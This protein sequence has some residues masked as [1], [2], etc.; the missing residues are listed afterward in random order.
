MLRKL[1]MPVSSLSALFLAAQGVVASA[2]TGRLNPGEGTFAD[3]AALSD[4]AGLVAR[5]EIKELAQVEPARASGVRVGYGRFYIEGKTGALLIGKA[6]LGE[7][8][9][10]LVD[11]PLDTYGDGPNLKRQDVF[12][13]ARRVPARPDELQLVTPTAQL[14]WSPK[15][16]ARLR[17]LLR[18]MVS[19]AAPPKVTGVREF[20]HVPGNLAGQGRT[21][22]FL[23]TED[24]SA[25]SIAVA[26][27][28][29]ASLSWGVSFSEVAAKGSNAPKR[30]TLE[31]YR[32]ACL[33]PD[34]PPPGA[35]LSKTEQ[36]RARALADYSF[37]LNELR[38]CNRTL[39]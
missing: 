12:V 32:L 17:E 19:Q 36:S 16:A 25:A 35:N 13:F 10:Y 9:K 38:P 2:Q 15:G 30:N 27:E 22:I 33:L 8:V 20:M 28:P 6:P 11:L 34:N 4:R 18:A 21:Q 31:W 14:P 26:H 23:S 39:E 3:V 29:G 5:V 24:G 1:Q 37:V 7:N